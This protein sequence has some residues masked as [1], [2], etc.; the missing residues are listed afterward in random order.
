MNPVKRLARYLLLGKRYSSDRYIKYLRKIGCSIGDNVTIY[1][2]EK[3]T[4]D[5]TA[6]YL[7]TVGDNVKMTGPFTILTHDYS[8]SVLNGKYG[9]MYGNQKPVVIKDNVF[10]GWGATILCGSVIESNTITGAHSIVSGHVEGDSVW[11]GV[12]AKKICGLEQYRIRRRDAQLDEAVNVVRAYKKHYK[13]EPPI[14][15]MYEYFP[16]FCG[17]EDL[18]E[19]FAFQVGLMGT[20]DKSMKVLESGCQRVFPSYKAFLE[21]CL[22]LEEE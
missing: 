10:I 8:W 22:K 15:A 17:D 16:L 1:Y 18:C 2:P 9:D 12:P 5:V 4:I 11:G 7:L 20:R 19:R 6:P 21:H 3:A 14:D 13:R